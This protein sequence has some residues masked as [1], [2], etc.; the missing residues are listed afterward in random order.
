M[1]YLKL[2]KLLYLADRR[3][4]L[5]L[6]RP[7][8]FDRYVSMD[9]GPVL[10]QT[11]NLMV[12]EPLPDRPSYWRQFIS[13]PVNYDVILQRETASDQLSAA[14]EQIIDSVFA[15]FGN[16]SRWDLV[17]ITHKLPEW[18]DPHGS[19]VPIDHRDV[20]TGA[21]MSEEIVAEV[22]ESLAAEDA[23]YALIGC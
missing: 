3:A 17:D 13:E 23:L 11:Y 20:L 21:G 1:S 12:G 9:Q 4:L 22:L 19:S 10:S 18:E 2:L 14:Q 7:I 15:E 5:E 6:G 16:R 8:T